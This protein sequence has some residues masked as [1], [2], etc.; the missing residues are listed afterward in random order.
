MNNLSFNNSMTKRSPY[1]P[2]DVAAEF[3]LPPD[4]PG[5]GIYICSIFGL[6]TTL[7]FI[8]ILPMR[9]ADNTWIDEAVNINATV[10][11]YDIQRGSHRVNRRYETYYTLYLILEYQKSNYHIFA[12]SHS[13]EE[14][15]I[16]EEMKYPINST[17]NGWYNKDKAPYIKLVY[18]RNNI[19][20]AV[21]VYFMLMF[22]FALSGYCFYKM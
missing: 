17:V 6:I 20:T 18:Y 15:V 2:L 14:Y 10:V 16:R 7:F 8:I 21:I 4:D 3:F 13:S 19:L 11:G 1:D 22:I 9:M 5:F 12:N